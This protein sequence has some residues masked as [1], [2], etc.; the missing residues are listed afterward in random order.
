MISIDQRL[1]E[2][3]GR[4]SGFDYLRLML[5][6]SVV[7]WHTVI[8]TEG[9]SGELKYWAGPLRPLISFLLPAFFALSGF[10]VAG[11]LQRN[12]LPSFLT[13]RI[14]RIFPALGVEVLISALII[15][16]IATQVD[17]AAY[18]T[19]PQFF[20]YFLNVVGD[21]HYALPGVFEH[22]PY[23]N[24]VNFQLWTVPYELQCYVSLSI[25]SLIGISKR[26]ESLWL[27]T[28]VIS[29]ILCIVKLLPGNQEPYASGPVGYVL[30]LSFLFG[31][32]IFIN[33]KEI[34]F[35]KTLFFVSLFAAIVLIYIP[36]LRILACLPITYV[37]IFIGL[38]NPVRIWPIQLADYSYGIFLYGSVMQQF[39][40]YILPNSRIWYI[41]LPVS[42]LLTTFFAAIS[43]HG[44]E[45]RVLGHRQ[46]V[47]AFVKSRTEALAGLRATLATRSARRGPK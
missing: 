42:L 15:G 41:H 32:A 5:S 29:L 11:S 16:P 14:L 24:K 10:L 38:L 21:I 23:P 43:W 13:L 35:S 44:V 12:D 47:L 6:I 27:V 17:L 25:L 20:W 9:A 4:P 40:C 36:G 39:V 18:F 45:S 33:K 30:V 7:V 37:V 3:D 22:L 1:R 2:T 28:G 46:R 8:V 34:G 31:V 19:D 26:K